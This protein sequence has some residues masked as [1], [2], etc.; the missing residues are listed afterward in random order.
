MP[1]IVREP[2]A[3]V[4]LTAIQDAIS[5]SVTLR[6]V[7]PMERGDDVTSYDVR[8]KPVG[9]AHYTYAPPVGTF[10]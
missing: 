2:G 8:F 5:G 7:P 9:A 6:W 3:V 4:G 1:L 10:S